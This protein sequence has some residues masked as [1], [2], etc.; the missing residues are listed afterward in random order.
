MR[1]RCN[2]N[3]WS[4]L[5]VGGVMAASALGQDASEPALPTD[6]DAPAGLGDLDALLG[7]EPDAA[8]PGQGAETGALDAIESELERALDGEAVAQTFEDAVRL[9]NDSAQRLAGMKDTG[10]DTQRMQAEA[11]R[12]LE[13][14]IKNAQQQQQQSQSQQQQQQQQQQNQPNQQQQEQQ[15]QQQGD[16]QQEMQ[17][18]GRQDG[19]LAEAAAADL[20]RWGA[21]PARMR[22][23]LL[24]G[25]DE[26]FSTL[27]R[28]LTEKY[29]E[30]LAEDAE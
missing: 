5:L 7:V 27:Y 25:A 17:P 15:Q 12:K 2:I 13:V 26:R 19:E 29:F 28:G 10:I 4:A 30:R 6:P 16:N 18:P 14:L 23:A 20:A 8:R 1:T 22:D 21:L 9:M 24:Q 3:R 11:I